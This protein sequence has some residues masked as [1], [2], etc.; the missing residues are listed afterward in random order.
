[1]DGFVNFYGI[2]SDNATGGIETY[3]KNRLK[4]VSEYILFTKE[5]SKLF[6][7]TNFL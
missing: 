3:Y 1:M 5:N 4:K 7:T 6:D 2:G